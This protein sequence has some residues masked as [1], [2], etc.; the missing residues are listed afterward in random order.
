MSDSDLSGAIK[1]L[2]GMLNTEDGQKKIEDILSTFT[3][4]EDTEKND[5]FNSD[6]I[7]MM[8]KIKKAMSVMNSVSNERQTVFLRSLGEMLNPSRREKVDNAIKIL[9][10]GKMIDVL[11]EI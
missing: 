8:M 5:G 9:N 4:K 11:K 3:N 7:E 1:M 2:E 10:M 6:D